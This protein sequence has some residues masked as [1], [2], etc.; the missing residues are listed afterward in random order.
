MTAN[1]ADS[2]LTCVGLRLG[3]AEANP[4]ASLFLSNTACIFAKQ[5]FIPVIAILGALLL[6]P[7][8]Y[9]IAAKAYCLLFAAVAGLNLFALTTGHSVVPDTSSTTS[10]TRLSWFL[11][12]YASMAAAFVIAFVH[13]YFTHL[14][15]GRGSS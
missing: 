10:F 7:T 3:Y 8:V 13:D 1:F 6:T 15:M 9:R 2:I 11:G 5:M 14:R 12:V 4:V